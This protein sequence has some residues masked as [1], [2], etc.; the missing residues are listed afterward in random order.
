M[1]FHCFKS[2]AL[3]L[4]KVRLLISCYDVVMTMSFTYGPEIRSPTHCLN[5]NL[6]D[7]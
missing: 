7:K 3:H 4:K 1:T 6:L 5:Y 2:N